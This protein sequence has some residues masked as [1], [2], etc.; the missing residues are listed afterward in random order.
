M[1]GVHGVLGGTPERWA[2]YGRA[3]RQAW[4]QAGHP[5]G[6][7]R[8]AVAVH[9]FVADDNAKA[10]AT[11]LEHELAM[12][13]AGAAEAGRPPMTPD[14]RDRD[15]Q[16]GGMVFAGHPDEIADRIIALH[17]LLEHDRQILQMDVGGMSQADLL[18]SIELLAPKSPHACAKN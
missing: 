17:R 14:G 3:Y 8:V 18:R 9:G 15:L 10:K 16:P 4:S 1:A 11:Y 12:F 13:A 5:S 7:A 6:T 2:R